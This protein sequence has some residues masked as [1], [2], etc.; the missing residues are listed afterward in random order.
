MTFKQTY[1]LYYSLNNAVGGDECMNVIGSD[2][3][4]VSHGLQIM[5]TPWSWKHPGDSV[6]KK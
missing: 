6:F 4:K 5:K 1:T 2:R 3:K